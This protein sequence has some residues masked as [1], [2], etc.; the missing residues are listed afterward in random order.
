MGLSTSP[1]K[2]E[3]WGGEKE[4]EKEKE[5]EEEEENEEADEKVLL[6][7]LLSDTVAKCSSKVRISR[8][9]YYKVTVV[10]KNK[11]QRSFGERIEISP[12]VFDNRES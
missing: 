6:K 1:K 10:A 5:E 12:R 7:Q 3:R 11:E 9:N 8:A 2:E 4:E